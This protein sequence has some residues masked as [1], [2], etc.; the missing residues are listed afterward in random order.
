MNEY[1]GFVPLA[2]ILVVLLLIAAIARNWHTRRWFL[3][4]AAVFSGGILAAAVASFL[5]ESSQKIVLT[6]ANGLMIL[7]YLFFSRR[8]LHTALVNGS[9]DYHKHRLGHRFVGGLGIILLAVS[10]VGTGILGWEWLGKYRTAALTLAIMG[11]WEV[12]GLRSRA[13]SAE[14]KPASTG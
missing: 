8:L 7:A 9:V 10:L 1:G 4:F 3:L 12:L 11:M 2:V 5:P 13:P 14:R 6:A